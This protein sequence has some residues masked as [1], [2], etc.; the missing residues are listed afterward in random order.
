MYKCTPSACLIYQK[1][2]S[3]NFKSK[4]KNYKI[5]FIQTIKFNKFEFQLGKRAKIFEIILLYIENIFEK[6]DNAKNEF[7]EF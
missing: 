1:C 7:S 2:T 6:F 4:F 3:Y 5:K